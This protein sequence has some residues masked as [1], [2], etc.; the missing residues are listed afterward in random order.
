MIAAMKGNQKKPIGE[1]IDAYLNCAKYDPGRCEH[2]M[3]VIRHYQSVGNYTFS[4]SLSKYCYDTYKKSPFPKSTLFIDDNVYNWQ[5]ADLHC[6]N[7][8]YTGRYTE[9]KQVYNKLRK[10]INKGLVPPDHVKRILDQSKWYEAKHIAEKNK[11]KKSKE[12]QFQPPLI[13]K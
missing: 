1:I 2:F 8:Y 13:E 7:C 4:Y 6:V 3:S 9:A 11:E 10:Q 5:I 12:S